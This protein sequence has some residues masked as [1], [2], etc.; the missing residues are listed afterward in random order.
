[1][2]G[3]PRTCIKSDK[4][5]IQF[6]V[7]WVCRIQL[8]ASG[9]WGSG[10]KVWGLGFR[11]ALTVRFVP[12]WLDSGLAIP[13]QSSPHI[14]ANNKSSHLAIDN[15]YHDHR[16]TDVFVHLASQLLVLDDRELRLHRLHPTLN[17]MQLPKTAT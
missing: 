12:N 4:E 2:Q 11:L 14:S 10:F 7:C 5:K 9:V 8:L 17:Q 1:M 13:A 6:L 15:S 16:W 3:P